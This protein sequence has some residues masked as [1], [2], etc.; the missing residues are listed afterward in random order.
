MIS[1]VK[2]K[3]E[4]SRFAQEYVSARLAS[5][6]ISIVPRWERKQEG[7]SENGPK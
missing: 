1:I 2:G 3:T 4:I 6:P 7:R 5:P